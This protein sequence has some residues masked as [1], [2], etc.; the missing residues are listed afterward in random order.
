MT[1]LR[2]LTVL[3][4]YWGRDQ[5]KAR[6]AI[7]AHMRDIRIRKACLGA[8]PFGSNM[9]LAGV[10]AVPPLHRTHHQHT[11]KAFCLALKQNPSFQR[12]EQGIPKDGIDFQR[13]FERREYNGDDFLLE[14]R[15]AMPHPEELREPTEDED[16]KAL[17]AKLRELSTRP[18]N[19]LETAVIVPVVPSYG[20]GATVSSMVYPLLEALAQNATLFAPSMRN[21]TSPSC[22]T[23]DLTCYFDSLPSLRTRAAQLHSQKHAHMLAAGVPKHHQVMLQRL[24]EPTEHDTAD[25]LCKAIQGL[26]M[27]CPQMMTV[28]RPK[29]INTALT[30]T[31]L[32]EQLPHKYR[33]AKAAHVLA[34]QKEPMF[35]AEGER[36]F[37][38]SQVV[39]Y[40]N[41]LREQK[42]RTHQDPDLSWV[43][44][45]F[46]SPL[47]LKKGKFNLTSLSSYD[48]M[49]FV[50]KID[51]RWLK[52]GRFWLMS[53]IIKFITTPN[54]RL[55]AKLEA[56]K[57]DLGPLERPVLGLHVRKGDACGDRGECRSLKDYMPTVN[58]MIHKYGYKTVFLA[59]PDPTVLDE[60]HNFPNVTF[61]FLP[62]T[63]TTDIMKAQNIRKIDIAIEKGMV[64][65]GN[66][67]DEAMISQYMLGEADGFI[68]GFSSN[69]ARIAY[70]MM[71]AGPTGCAKPYDSFDLNWCGAFGKGGG[72]VL[73]AGNQTCQDAQDA[74]EHAL[75]CEISC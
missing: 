6:A 21:W 13:A 63:N 14:N 23:R 44:E 18:L 74:G 11:N 67:F 51:K 39:T 53:Q 55:K 33:K 24:N 28:H 56:H 17:F 68:G 66:E 42:A 19:S 71:A 41:Q 45:L 9:L 37:P 27:G 26:G 35:G 46:H 31:L 58:K 75:P 50:S 52:R 4:S 20:V 72:G 5:D 7:L 49:S 22:A 38:I 73:R 48:E 54:A 70:S 62:V 43:R 16:A 65:A 61:K 60:V 64:D 12:L 25:T 57:K 1:G 30:Q 47:G 10:L 36:Q 29:P 34:A 59:T 15:N 3:Y 2:F 32:Q 8:A 69:A 40:A